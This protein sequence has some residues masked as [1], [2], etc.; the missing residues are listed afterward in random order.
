[1]AGSWNPDDFQGKR[2]DH[3]AFSSDIAGTIGPVFLVLLLAALL[4]PLF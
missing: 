1:M 3:V 2:E 4:L